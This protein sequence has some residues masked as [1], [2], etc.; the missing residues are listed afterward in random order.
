MIT[1]AIKRMPNIQTNCACVYAKT[2][3]YAYTMRGCQIYKRI[4]HVSMLK[5]QHAYTMTADAIKS[6]PNIQT[7]CACAY[8]KA[9]AYAYTMIADAI[10]RMRMI[11]TQAGVLNQKHEFWRGN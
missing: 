10:K 3:A 6:M 11:Q 4:L 2:T 9:T 1:D 8:T 7:S 5:L